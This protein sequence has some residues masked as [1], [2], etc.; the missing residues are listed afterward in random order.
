MNKIQL[1]TYFHSINRD[2][3][4]NKAKMHLPNVTAAVLAALLIYTAAEITWLFFTPA[5]EAHSSATS[6][7]SDF[8]LINITKSDLHDVSQ[9]HLFG[10]AKKQPVI[11]QKIIDAPETRL[12]LTLKGVF[13]TS[14]ANNALAIISSSKDKDKNYHIGD[15]VMGG[16]VLHAIYTD[17][18]ILKRNGRLETLR[19]PKAKLDS[20]S[21]TKV[22]IESAPARINPVKKQK[23]LQTNGKTQQQ[24]LRKMRDTLLKDP[25]KIWQQVRINPVMEQGKIKGY[26]LSHN[27]QAFM[28]ALNIQ[29]SDVITAINGEALSDPSTLYGLMSNLSTQ[30][31][32]ELTILRDGVQQSVYLSF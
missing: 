10:N 18:V 5:K 24:Q 19:L 9:Y 31:S 1:T 11:Q 17:R 29:T 15:K 14:E 13:A 25:S 26:T 16:A 21:I 6:N 3:Y 4:I 28:Q 30:S 12:K 23:S 2:D 22:K 20:E 7:T 27:D 32:L 8:S